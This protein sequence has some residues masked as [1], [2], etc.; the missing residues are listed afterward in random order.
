MPNPTKLGQLTID[1]VAA[2]RERAR[3][4]ERLANLNLSDEE[5]QTAIDDYAAAS[6]AFDKAREAVVSAASK[7]TSK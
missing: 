2:H 4:F 1:F 5:R 6:K 7:P 3:L